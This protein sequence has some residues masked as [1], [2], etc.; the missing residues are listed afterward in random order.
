TPLA[1]A[2]VNYSTGNLH[3]LNGAGSTDANGQITIPNIGEGPFLVEAFNFNTFRF[4]GSTQGTINPGDDGQ[5]VSV[6]ITAPI[7]GTVQGTVFAG[8]GQTPIPNTSVQILDGPFGRQLSSGFT[9]QNGFY[10]LTNVTV[11]S[12]FTVQA[13]AQSFNFSAVGQQN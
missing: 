9:D 7:A 2:F 12:S 1:N 8:D 11:G 13:E 10:Q 5:I 6:T 3:F 4:A